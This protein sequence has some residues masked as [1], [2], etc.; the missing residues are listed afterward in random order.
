[1]GTLRYHK[2]SFFNTLLGFSPY[3]EYKT[4]NAFHADSPGVYIS[5]KISN[6][7]T[8]DKNYMKRDVIAGSIQNGLRQPIFCSFV[9]DKPSGYIYFLPTRNNTLQ[10]K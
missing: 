4:T 10:K 9:L 8:I 6:L 7:K 3:W 5:D 2:K 1:M